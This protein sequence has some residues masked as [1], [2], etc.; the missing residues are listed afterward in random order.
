MPDNTVTTQEIDWRT[1]VEQ[2]EDLEA[3][4]RAYVF[5]GRTFFEDDTD[6]VYDDS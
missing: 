4:H 6:G 5:S 3:A 1:V 2:H